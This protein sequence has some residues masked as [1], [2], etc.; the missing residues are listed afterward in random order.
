M[1]LTMM[2]VHAHPDDE[3]ITT[4]GVLA[5]YAA[6]GITTIVVTCTG[7]EVGEISDPALATPANLAEIRARELAAALRR[8]GVRQGE[9]LGYRDSGM[10]G[11]AD[12]QHPRSFWQADV[13]AATG[14]LVALVRRLQPDV[15]VAYNEHGDYGHPDHIQAH[16]IAVAAF[17]TAGDATCYPEQGLAPWTPRKL[18]YSAIPR[19]QAD[20]MRQIER[21]AG[22][23]SAAGDSE[24]AFPEEL[25]T[26]DE[27][28]TTVIDV[29]A[30]ID[31]K[32]DALEAHRTQMGPPLWFSTVPRS[33][34]RSVWATEHFVRAASRV[35][36]PDREDDLF[37]GLR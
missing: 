8:L 15:I 20:R 33:V 2:A 6:E 34:W 36:A 28:I 17:H 3:S 4:G 5:R 13:D 19:S 16:R 12:N 18:Y 35:P 29:S 14:K 11:T 24:D 25:I 10:M 1:P 26:P 27:R 37:A 30:S 23:S 31:A 22:L 21:E 7:G 32:L 9:Q